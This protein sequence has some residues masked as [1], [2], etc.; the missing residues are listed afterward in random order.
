MGIGA[1]GEET[2][3]RASEWWHGRGEHGGA[4]SEGDLVE[5][6]AR[7]DEDKRDENEPFDGGVRWTATVT[8][9]K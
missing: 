5:R 4:I 9:G 8:H 3:T 7:G 2:A 6:P 1:E